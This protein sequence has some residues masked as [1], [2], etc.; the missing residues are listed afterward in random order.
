[1]KTY[2]YTTRELE[3]QKKLGRALLI[4]GIALLIVGGALYGL[5]ETD[6]ALL[7]A[8]LGPVV[9]LGAIKPLAWLRRYRKLLSAEVQIDDAGIA[10]AGAENPEVNQHT[11]WDEVTAAKLYQAK[12]MQST[13]RT[14]ATL[15]IIYGTPGA[16]VGPLEYLILQTTAGKSV[17]MWDR[18]AGWQEILEQVKAHLQPRGIAL[19]RGE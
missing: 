14:Q 17:I 19:E 12:G 2:P 7:P 5:L 9:A 1:M 6:L 11:R 16:A 4:G 8:I 18:F 15:A 3:D 13:L 10:V